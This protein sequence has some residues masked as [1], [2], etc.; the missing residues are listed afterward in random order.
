MLISKGVILTD[1][2][3]TKMR[4]R[5]EQGQF[6]ASCG[7]MSV[8]AECCSLRTHF[9]GRRGPI[10]HAAEKEVT[11]DWKVALRSFDDVLN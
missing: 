10:V 8:L 9:R 2:L 11:D 7:L 5:H 3:P 6:T 1:F 4:C